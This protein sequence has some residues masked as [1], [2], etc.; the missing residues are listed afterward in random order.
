M[1]KKITKTINVS[2]LS[3]LD[4][5]DEIMFKMGNSKK[6]VLT[7]IIKDVYYFWSDKNLLTHTKGDKLFY[8]NGKILFITTQSDI[9]NFL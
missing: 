2:E 6:Y 9:R 1:R 4:V 8:L 5:G 7:H 3:T